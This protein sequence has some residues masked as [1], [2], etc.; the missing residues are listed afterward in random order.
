MTR[1]QQQTPDPSLPEYGVVGDAGGGVCGVTDGRVTPPL[2]HRVVTDTARRV[3]LQGNRRVVRREQTVLC[4][5]D[6]ENSILFQVPI[7]CP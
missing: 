4:H 5:L 7:F 1:Q 2:V 3:L 6:K